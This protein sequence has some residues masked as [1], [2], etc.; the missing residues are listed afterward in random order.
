MG[1]RYSGK[2][3]VRFLE[4]GS[5]R[6]C[7]NFFI[8]GISESAREAMA[9]RIA[10]SVEKNEAIHFSGIEKSFTILMPYFND[11][12]GAE[13]FLQHL[14][15]S[16]NIAQDCYEEFRGIIMIELDKQWAGEETNGSLYGIIDF[17]RKMNHI[18]YILLFPA[19]ENN[20]RTDSF[21]KE[22]CS[23]G[24]WINVSVPSP[25]PGVCLHRFKKIVGLNGFSVDR[26]AENALL[27][28]LQHRNEEYVDNLAAVE[29]LADR[30]LFEK[31]T[32]GDNKRVVSEADVLWMPGTDARKK[33]KIGFIGEITGREGDTN[34]SKWTG[35]Q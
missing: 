7:P 30:V 27:E 5:F 15:N 13:K 10:S 23:S 20:P 28:M 6:T 11:A 2:D 9:M 24:N 31:N 29:L 17:F 34:V 8:Y 25:D 19:H 21:Y 14:K 16:I 3:V 33:V 12:M 26:K 22:L 1:N 35:L 18:C 4:H 32:S